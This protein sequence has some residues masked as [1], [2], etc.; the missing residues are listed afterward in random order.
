MESIYV[1]IHPSGAET[2]IVAT[3]ATGMVVLKARVTSH[4]S[5]PSALP[6]LLDA[7]SIWEGKFVRA[8]LVVD[9]PGDQP[10]SSLYRDIFPAFGNERY[11]L[12][13]V[14]AQPTR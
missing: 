5:S 12:E 10:A 14:L 4:P 9:A 2:R 8:A 7:L 11:S 6:A 3:S 1:A 13:Y